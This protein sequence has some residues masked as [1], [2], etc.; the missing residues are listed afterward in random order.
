MA[1]A[2][3]D[4]TGEKF[5]KLNKETVHNKA[6]F[7]NM[8]QSQFKGVRLA[9]VI[10]IILTFL[11][12]IPNSNRGEKVLSEGECLRDYLFIWTNEI[13]DY[14][15]KN[16]KIKNQYMIYSSALMDFI[17]LSGIA[18]YVLK[19]KTNRG[20]C[21]FALFMIPRAWIQAHFLMGR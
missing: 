20:A 11:Y 13:N 19:F 6:I 2:V 9:V 3:N 5:R 16:I 1:A 7:K 18:H 4:A 21:A 12:N 8:D 15:A 14:L 17:Q 10:F